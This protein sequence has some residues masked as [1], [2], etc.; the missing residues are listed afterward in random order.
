[1]TVRRPGNAHGIDS[2]YHDVRERW[3]RPTLS[4]VVCIPRCHRA[5]WHRGTGHDAAERVTHDPDQRRP[6][7]RVTRGGG[8]TST[9]L[10]DGHRGDDGRCSQKQRTM[11]DSHDASRYCGML[12]HVDPRPAEDTN[13]H[14]FRSA[15]IQSN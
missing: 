15:T 2:V 7:N 13:V 1:M 12:H 9:R 8:L 3:K 14:W 10:R 4:V 5:P 6:G 11:P